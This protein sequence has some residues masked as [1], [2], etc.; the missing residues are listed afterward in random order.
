METLRKTEALILTNPSNNKLSDN[1]AAQ[2]SEELSL[3]DRKALNRQRLE[4]RVTWN[5]VPKSLRNSSD[6]SQHDQ[7][8]LG[9]YV[10]DS[11]EPAESDLLSPSSPVTDLWRDSGFIQ[12]CDV[13][14]T[15][16]ESQS[17]TMATRVRSSKLPKDRPMSAQP[18]T[19]HHSSMTVAS[20][21]GFSTFADQEN[22]G[23]SSDSPSV[24]DRRERTSPDPPTVS[25]RPQ[26]AGGRNDLL[27][28]PPPVNGSG[29]DVLVASSVNTLSPSAAQRASMLQGSLMR[30]LQ[31]EKERGLFKPVLDSV[32][33]IASLRTPVPDPPVPAA[34]LQD[35]G[36]DS[37]EDEVELFM[38][39]RIFFSDLETELSVDETGIEDLERFEP[40]RVLI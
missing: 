17:F 18:S 40:I 39:R 6:A 19:W 22:P 12:D 13:S 23:T 7:S 28:I 33:G 20:R 27:L 9:T 38:A 1:E 30:A 25:D 37:E 26:Q 2:D 21:N 16:S 11:E 32:G 34:S 14:E 3:E 4:R 24:L 5:H 35:D 15:P 29:S 31:R 8:L 36:Q 10:P